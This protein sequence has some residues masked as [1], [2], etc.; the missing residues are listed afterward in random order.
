MAIMTI[1]N[2]Y[3]L[4]VETVQTLE[5]LASRWKVSKSEALRRAIKAAAQEHSRPAVALRALNML[6]Q[7]LKISAPQA[8][9]WVAG[10]RAERSAASARRLGRL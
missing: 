1:R 3:A 10:I 6:Q 8:H 2:T 4:D 5:R 9:R 7:S